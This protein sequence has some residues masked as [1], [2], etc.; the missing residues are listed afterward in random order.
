MAAV[1]QGVVV[2]AGHALDHSDKYDVVG[3][4]DPE[5]GAGGSIPKERAFSVGQVGLGRIEDDG[6]VESV[7]EAGA[8]D[9]LA[10]AE[11]AGEDLGG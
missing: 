11:L 3:G 8:H 10:D 6:A 7:A 5:P 4:V 1:D 9:V 2:G